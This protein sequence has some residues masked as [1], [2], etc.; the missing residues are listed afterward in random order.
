MSSEYDPPQIPSGSNSTPRKVWNDPQPGR[1]RTGP[2]G[3]SLG[4][5][6]FLDVI[7]PLQ[8]IPVVS[9]IY[10]AITGDQISPGARLIGGT[11][12]GGPVGMV[13]ASANIVSEMK[14]G[15]DVGERM[16]AS[17][18]GLPAPVKPPAPGALPPEAP[19]GDPIDTKNVLASADEGL[20]A[21]QVAM[22]GP[23]AASPWGA[24]LPR[25]E[26][27]EPVRSAIAP[28]P[29]PQTFRIPPIPSR[30]QDV[31]ASREAADSEVAPA[32][33]QGAIG[34]LASRDDMTPPA[35]SAGPAPLVVPRERTA[36]VDRTQFL[37]PATENLGVG[38]Q[39]VSS[40]PDDLA[41][42]SLAAL[43]ADRPAGLQTSVLPPGIHPSSP[44]GMA[45]V[46]PLAQPLERA[47]LPANGPARAA[48]GQRE[49]QERT[50]AERLEAERLDA[51]RWES[52]RRA[53]ALA[54]GRAL[55]NATESSRPPG[56]LDLAG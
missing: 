31:M 39:P 36:A 56:S 26:V 46:G 16:V 7:N 35:D 33:R 48:N 3:E 18:L 2:N 13:V 1:P 14:T 47:G 30:R 29:E 34:T 41:M 54:L 24:D 17:A 21:E 9:T 27:A 25:A 51:E 15:G 52:D 22:A 23:P 11:L 10:R 43:G 37:P 28:A 42:N 4:F 45:L 50:D 38:A 49:E 8:H 19:S 5:K 12:L 53:A 32:A 55:R 44:G 6:D 40:A 20:A